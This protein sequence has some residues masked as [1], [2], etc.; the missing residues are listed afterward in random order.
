MTTTKSTVALVA[1]DS[2]DQEVVDAALRRAVDLGGGA[3]AFVK[4]G[5]TIVLKPNVLVGSSPDKSVVTHPAVFRAAIEIFREAGAVLT[6]GDSSG[7]GGTALNMRLAGLKQVADELGV[8]LAEFSHGKTVSHPD[9]LLYHQFLIAKGVLEA[10]GL[11]SL[12]KLKTHGLTRLTGAVKNQFGCIPGLAKAQ[13][14]ARL[15]DPRDFATMLVDLNTLLRP[16]LYVMDGVMAMEGNGPRSGNPRKIGVILASTDPIALDAT[17]ARLVAL[18]PSFMPTAEPGER[19]GLGTYHEENIEIVGDKLADFV[20]PDFD[21][22]REPVESR[23]GGRLLAF[24]KNRMSPRPFIDET[25]CTRC[26]TCVAHCPVTPRAVDWRNGDKER[27]PIYDYGRCI[28]CFCCQ[29][30]CPQAAISIRQ[31]LLGKLLNR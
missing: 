26:G 20:C 30:L 6:C 14:H 31:P 22:V 25:K 11:I 28:R 17:M 8:P 12:S 1:C 19:S 16:R 21:V 4:P 24:A 5:E 29:E 18:D 9:A 23:K 27:P 3:A 10:D 2:Y 13:Q 7:A 15:P